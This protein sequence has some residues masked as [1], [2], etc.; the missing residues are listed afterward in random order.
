MS[1]QK[2]DLEVVLRR[3]EKLEKRLEKLKNETNETRFWGRWGPLIYLLI[4]AALPVGLGVGNSMRS[5][6][7]PD[8]LASV[9]GEEFVLKDAGG[10]LRAKLIVRGNLPQL[11]LF[12]FE[13]RPGTPLVGER[14]LSPAADEGNR[15]GAAQAPAGQTQSAQAQAAQRTPVDEVRR[16]RQSTAASP[17]PEVK[18]QPG[19]NLVARLARDPFVYAAGGRHP[20]TAALSARRGGGAAAGPLRLPLRGVAPPAAAPR[21]APSGEPA[22][23]LPTPPAAALPFSP[24]TLPPVKLTILGYVEKPGV[25]REVAV[26]DN[27]EVYVTHEGETFA[28]RFK[29]V[30]I[31][32]TLVEVFDTYTNQNLRLGISP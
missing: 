18:S 8:Q 7:Q 32:P 12:D 10:R 4:G 22:S 14:V 19:E 2:P 3:L 30:K 17:P 15:G 21:A 26:S 28:E 24:E 1:S 5:L 6:G 29:V 9:E 31:T 13:N 20:T 27:I 23:G 11:T 16:A 25:G